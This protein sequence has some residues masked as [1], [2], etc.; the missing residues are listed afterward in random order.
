MRA[1]AYG[2]VGLWPGLMIGVS[3]L[4]LAAP[5]E[6]AT[7]HVRHASTSST[8][9]TAI[10]QQL[11]ALQDRVTQQDATI[12]SQQ[13]EIDQ[14][15]QEQQDKLL[16][17]VHS[18]EPIAAQI[19]Q[20]APTATMVPSQVL[21]SGDG[22]PVRPAAGAAPTPNMALAQN[23]PPAGV[24]APGPMPSP[25]RP[26]GEA[27]ASAHQVQELAA[28]PET[29]GV[30]TPKGH[31][32]L[33]PSFQY[34]R[35][36]NN[37]LVFRGVEIVP[38]VQLGVIDANTTASDTGVGT[39]SMRYGV[40]S[41][42]EIEAQ[43]P[44]VTRSD[45]VTTVAQRDQ[46]VEQTEKLRGNDIGDIDLSARY[47]I[48]DVRPGMPIFIANAQIKPPTGRGPYDTQY[49][50]FGVATTLATGSGFW[51][52]EGGITML[53]PSDPAVI[54]GG[55]TFNH[56]FSKDV[57]KTIGGALV[58]KVIPGDSIGATMGFG[59]SLNPRFSV[60]LGYSHNYIFE[61]R[62]ELNGNWQRSTSLQVGSL[63]MGWSYRINDHTT[64]STN[65]EFGVT[66]DAPDLQ[67]TISLPMKF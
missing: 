14:M 56:N 20:A 57:N 9:L 10:Q 44:Y 24:P 1:Y 59:L 65:F 16:A 31:F 36:S 26:V 51:G 53:Y 30:L 60:S 6:A 50:Q 62:T 28:L 13:A 4:A 46:T 25:Q 41:R 49:D 43:I 61:T 38:G 21:P 35:A 40:T 63:L 3:V 2:R 64:L 32:V 37:R 66:S 39:L 29:V 34:V 67:A 33:E 55:L 5:A 22:L 47:Q 48:N 7:R 15:H 19:A 8:Q 23:T 42:F 18:Q 58:G 45:L 17:D 27:P 12:K 11:Q 54:F 52:A